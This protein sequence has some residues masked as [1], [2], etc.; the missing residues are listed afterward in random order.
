[1]QVLC[2]PCILHYLNTSENT[3]WARCPICF[4]SVNEKQLKC[5]KWYDEVDNLRAEGSSASGPDSASTSI[6]REGSTM[7][8]RLM[9]RPQITTLA[10]PRS[11]TWPSDL[12]SP[13]QAPFHFL[14]DVYHYA[15]FMLATPAY[16][17]SDLTRDLDDLASE[18]QTLV[19][20]KDELGI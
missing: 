15:K 6:P 17:I 3:K 11:H 19:S 5:V 8:M 9:Q 14:P 13:H 18:R 16:L 1:M 12:V 7:R 10:H 4:D 20:T 2:F